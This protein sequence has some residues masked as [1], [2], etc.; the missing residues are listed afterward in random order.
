MLSRR[1]PHAPAPNAWARLLDQRRHA[2]ASLIDLTESNPTRVGLS[3]A[4]GAELAA[5]ADLRGARYEPD[6][7][8]SRAAREAVAALY[9]E[10]GIE[11]TP[12]RVVLVASTSE[13]YAHLFRLLA[14]PGE[15]VLAPRPSYPLFEPLAAAEGVEI[16]PY[17]LAH[18]GRWHLDAHGL[19]RAFGPRTR[20]AIVVQ[21]NHPTGSCLDPAEVALLESLCERH[22]AGLISDEVFGDHAWPAAGGVV[23]EPR[24]LPSLIGPRRVPTFALGG[25]S[26]TCGMPQ[27]K[28]GWIVLAGP[29][30]A[31]E[32]ALAGLEWI[33]DLFLSVSTPVEL[34]LPRLLAAR[35]GFQA[36][37]RER[38]RANL[39]ALDDCARRR[40]ELSRLH[41][42]GGWSA[43]LRLPARRDEE[44]WALEL[45]RRDVIVHPGHFYDF[46]SGPHLVL[47]LIVEPEVFAR[48]LE[49][50]EALL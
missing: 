46:E 18:D 17:R 45:L 34:A 23:P 39:A 41:A 28:L 16:R 44:E 20:A 8:G 32:H 22:A 43:T 7:R 35:H 15:E 21:P 9:A 11:V 2:G 37:V 3:G 47:S 4:G 25:L 36:R 29:R 5:L 1:V 30:E 49:R 6:P 42:V 19:E 13:A 12:D 10:R 27:L 50:L 31:C 24:A 33:A 26:K 38:L 40:P 48:G 14:D